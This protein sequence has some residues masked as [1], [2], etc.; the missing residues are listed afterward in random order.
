MQLDPSG[1]HP[2]PQFPWG[3]KFGFPLVTG[4]DCEV[5]EGR[6]AGDEGMLQL[7]EACVVPVQVYISEISHPGVR[8]MLGACPQIMAVLGSL[9]LYALGKYLRGVSVCRAR[10]QGGGVKINN[11]PSKLRACSPRPHHHSCAEGAAQ[12]H[13]HPLPWCACSER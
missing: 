2:E 9:V 4:D 5:T 12:G 6:A 11:L 7:C 3:T 13:S 1:P 10:M 8:G